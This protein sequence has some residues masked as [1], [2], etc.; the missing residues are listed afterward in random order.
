MIIDAS[1]DAFFNAPNAE[2]EVLDK[3]ALRLRELIN[4]ELGRAIGVGDTDETLR[5]CRMFAPLRCTDEALDVYY[6][7]LQQRVISFADRIFSRLSTA[8][9]T[10][11]TTSAK[12]SHEPNGDALVL[13]ALNDSEDRVADTHL[14]CSDALTEL[15]EC[16]A[17]AIDDQRNLLHIDALFGVGALRYVI[18]HLQAQVGVRACVCE[19]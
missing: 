7:H 12:S 9:T 6:H 14:S 19:V 1:T 16:V 3:E 17:S 15:F 8:A 4:D 13:R 2:A 10:T 11:T 5:F 18:G